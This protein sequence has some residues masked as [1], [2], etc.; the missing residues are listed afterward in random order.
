MSC[1]LTYKG[2][3]FNSKQE[4]EDNL[5]ASFL[6]S[7]TPLMKHLISKLGNKGKAYQYQSLISTPI[8]QNWAKANLQSLAPNIKVFNRF[9]Q[10]AITNPEIRRQAILNEDSPQ[11]SNSNTFDAEE[12]EAISDILNNKLLGD[13]PVVG[14][15]MLDKKRAVSRYERRI[16]RFKSKISR[17]KDI[18]ERR[19]FREKK[20][21]LE[22]EVADLKNELLQLD[23]SDNLYIIKEMMDRELEWVE[24]AIHSNITLFKKDALADISEAEE[25][26]HSWAKF[27]NILNKIEP[28]TKLIDELFNE[29]KIT[30]LLGTIKDKQALLLLEITKDKSGFTN[31]HKAIRSMY[32]AAKDTSWTAGNLR[33]ASGSKHIIIQH[34]R[35][36]IADANRKT[37]KEMQDLFTGDFAKMEEA[38]RETLAE[39]G[40]DWDIFFS[41]DEKGNMLDKI[42]TPHSGKYFTQRRIR[43]PYTGKKGK[44]LSYNKW[45]I[46]NHHMIDPVRAMEDRVAYES[47]LNRLVDS[48]HAVAV[49]L[50]ESVRKYEKY[51]LFREEQEVGLEEKFPDPEQRANILNAWAKAHNPTEIIKDEKPYIQLRTKRKAKKLEFTQGLPLKESGGVETGYYDKNFAII[52]KHEALI[53]FQRTFVNIMHDLNLLLPGEIDANFT[54]PL[55]QKSVIGAWQGS[56]VKATGRA[57]YDGIIN[58]L[59]GTDMVDD[60]IIEE[61]PQGERRLATNFLSKTQG[62]INN[63]HNVE[64]QKWELENP[65]KVLSKQE[66]K[67]LRN[68]ATDRVVKESSQ[69][70]GKNLKMFASLVLAYKHKAEIETEVA[71]AE[72]VFKDRVRKAKTDR[73]GKIVYRD[74]E[75][76]FTTNP[77]NLET[78][79]PVGLEGEN[80][81]LTHEMTRLEA[82]VD[83]YYG[84]P[85]DKGEATKIKSIFKAF[86]YTAE[87]K[88]LLE[89]YEDLDHRIDIA[90]QALKEKLILKQINKKEADK[91]M[92][93]LDAQQEELEEKIAKVGGTF[94][95]GGIVN[96]L[97]QWVQLKSLG[98]NIT[99]SFA[100]VGFGVLTNNV[101][102]AGE[103][104]YSKEGMKKGYSLIKHSFAKTFGGGGDVG[105]KIRNL[106][107]EN[108]VLKKPSEEFFEIRGERNGIKKYY[109]PYVFTDMTEYLNQGPVMIAVLDTLTLTTKEGEEISL[110]EAYDER[111]GWKESVGN[112]ADYEDILSHASNTIDAAIRNNHGNYDNYSA[113]IAIKRGWFLKLFTQFR[114]WMFEGMFNRFGDEV[115]DY[116]L[117]FTR[118]GR[119]RTYADLGVATSIKSLKNLLLKQDLNAE[120]SEIDTINL[121]KNLRE[122]RNYLILGAANLLLLAL[123]KALKDDDEDD[124]DWAILLFLLNL[125]SRLQTDIL[126]YISP[127]EFRKIAGKDAIPILTIYD[128]WSRVFSSTLKL[129]HGEDTLDTGPYKG[130]SRT[131]RDLSKA[132][133]IT[134]SGYKI[135]N[136]TVQ[137]LDKNK[138]FFEELLLEDNKEDQENN[139]RR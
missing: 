135:I 82:L 40:L 59:R 29:T 19:R 134:A 89:E 14:E 106:M 93:S 65:G 24:H 125:T 31:E 32:H 53:D 130:W 70:V 62:K 49:A 91:Q 111:G 55:F 6:A 113:P 30:R 61:N 45:Y 122:I 60:I 76:E 41:K 5:K 1:L 131:G 79:V 54:I 139:K 42:V 73:A 4:L 33:D 128:D 17:S 23:E 21:S 9:I 81:E 88:K 75:G 78:A 85:K 112:K 25:V 15:L 28:D 92:A 47:E 90:K 99:S 64:T 63:Y 36:R 12:Q 105:V 123:A 80:S 39:L 58:T 97:M 71:L 18:N 10:E 38:A 43:N 103:Q 104:F 72:K 96:G 22:Q 86:K 118:K 94:T 8:Y 137:L 48:P 7:D 119:W 35:S 124:D 116:E 68:I 101:E 74:E 129:L 77:V 46:D 27:I 2:Q 26:L 3:R 11:I 117:G 126:L 52:E 13:K 50:D 136:N 83:T 114:T 67:E 20:V 102:A 69:D 133:P 127:V 57:Y 138:G 56:D 132:I 95:T 84:V 51:F 98:W 66:S 16:A 108:N 100:N 121:K 115:E 109:N 110:W 44:E 120:L 107:D 87:D 34:M 37:H